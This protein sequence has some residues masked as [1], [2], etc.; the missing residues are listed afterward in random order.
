M[1]SA[2]VSATFGAALV[3]EWRALGV[4]L[5]VVSP[6]SRSTP[7]A[8]AVAESPL[9]VE[10]FHDERSA[11]FAALGAAK[12]T[13]VPTLLLCT[14]GTAAV[15]FHPAVVEAS[16]AQVP[17]I[18]VTA[19]RPPELQG[20]GAP[21]TIDQRQL[22]GPAVRAFID[23]GVADDERRHEWRATATR[24]F[25]AATG[26]SPG[27]VQVNVAFREPLVGSVGV[28][29]PRAASASS[30]Q[31]SVSRRLATQQ[32]S[33]LLS[34]LT[35]RRG[36]IVAGAGRTSAAQM[37]ELAARLA[38]P[39]LSDPLSGTRTEH[40]RAVRHADALLRDADL[41]RRLQPQVVLR[42][43]ALPASKVVN[44]FLRDCAAET[45]T[46]TDTPRLADPDRRTS[47]HLVTDTDAACRDLASLVKPC[48]AAWCDAWN[49]AELAARAVVAAMLDDEAVLS[50]PGIA[51]TVAAS[52][53]VGAQLFV[54][55][56][57][58]VRDLEWYAGA[59]DHLVVLANRG[60]NGIDG[61][62]SSA[63]GAAIGTGRTTGLLIGDVAFL[64]DTNGLLG[65]AARG[66]DLRIVVVDNRGGGIFSFLPQRASMPT[67][68][69]EQLFGTPHSADLGA[70]AAAHG[71]A[72]VSVR[73]TTQL[74]EAISEP[75]P[76]VITVRTD[77]DENVARHDE[78]HRAV[79]Q[80]AR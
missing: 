32:V 48:E 28:L 54:S 72:H 47:L 27:P 56:S 18:V 49:R 42:F 21:Q 63:L 46:L 40:S 58:P 5:A 38:W 10:V 60:A 26:D 59:T 19:D 34:R 75:G 8:L 35:G 70:L 65:L 76:R 6:G 7:M 67:E 50:E 52:L 45:I 9:R 25:V 79:A 69:F 57:M 17:L 77:R 80:R 24:A 31:Q 61:V 23:I 64:H 20:V 14:S 33:D 30:R 37:H 12:A 44:G 78:I 55:S 11:A 71:V 43:G 36:I 41:A 39:I 53:P 66:V 22:F 15:N 73:S 16:Y 29:P 3:D 62:V 51:R 4:R 13:G 2:D 68:R 74:R 1:Q